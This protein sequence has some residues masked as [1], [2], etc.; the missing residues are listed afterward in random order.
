MIGSFLARAGHLIG[1]AVA[2]FGYG[3]NGAEKTFSVVCFTT[4]TI[5]RA[6][7][8]TT[9]TPAAALVGTLD[10]HAV[11][12]TQIVPRASIQSTTEAC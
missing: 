6:S 2:S 7:F 8:A 12:A 1:R 10:P 5:P 11:L 9:L 3:S 4:T